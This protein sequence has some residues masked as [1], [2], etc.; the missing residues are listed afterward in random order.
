MSL[1]NEIQRDLQ[2]AHECD[3]PGVMTFAG[4]D[5]PCSVTS[6]RKGETFDLGGAEYQVIFSLVVRKNAVASDGTLFSSITE[7]RLLQDI[8][9]TRGANETA[10][11]FT[12]AEKEDMHGAALV[13]GL[14]DPKASK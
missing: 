12:I 3:A 10:E 14:H 11:T 4:H 7:P 1:T 5:F 2:R 13:L 9:V 8:E 6:L